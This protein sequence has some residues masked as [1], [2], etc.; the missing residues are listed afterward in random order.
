MEEKVRR[1]RG[2]I[3]LTEN[4]KK[5][6]KKTG[7]CIKKILPK[8]LNKKVN[9]KRYLDKLI[10]SPTF[11]LVLK[12]LIYDLTI[13][14]KLTDKIVNKFL[15]KPEVAFELNRYLTWAR[16]KEED[17]SYDK[18]YNFIEEFSIKEKEIEEL[19]ELERIEVD[20]TIEV[21]LKQL[22]IKS[23]CYLKRYGYM[24]KMI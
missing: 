1:K 2:E 3:L 12:F 4:F 7:K 13:D 5:R 8:A 24:R 21:F 9:N 17:I 18:I 23:S 20:S 15:M 11:I 14:D 16:W 19:K 6:K 22:D 10:Y